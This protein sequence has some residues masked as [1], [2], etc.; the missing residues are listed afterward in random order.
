MPISP[1]E[2]R[3]AD[4]LWNSRQTRAIG[5]KFW[6][7]TLWHPHKAKALIVASAA[8]CAAAGETGGFATNWFHAGD[9]EAATGT[10]IAMTRGEFA[11]RQREIV[12]TCFA[13]ESEFDTGFAPLPSVRGNSAAAS[14][15]VREEMREFVAQRAINF[16]VAK[17][18]QSWIQ[19]H[20]RLRWK[21]SACGA[22]HARVPTDS[23]ARGEFCAAEFEKERSGECLPAILLLRLPFVHSSR[24]SFWRTR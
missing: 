12:A 18:A 17:V 5:L 14:A 20:E 23:D 10:S 11:A 8:V 22:A 2:A 16:V 21:R 1:E 24:C 7:R 3:D 4:Q 15:V 6:L 19:V 13:G 9:L